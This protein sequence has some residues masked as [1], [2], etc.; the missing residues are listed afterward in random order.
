MA[1]RKSISSYEKKCSFNLRT[2]SKDLFVLYTNCF[3]VSKP[4]NNNIPLDENDKY[5]IQ[6]ESILYFLYLLFDSG[7]KYIRYKKPLLSPAYNL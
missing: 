5:I 7:S 6:N 4:I 2:H 3:P 1:L